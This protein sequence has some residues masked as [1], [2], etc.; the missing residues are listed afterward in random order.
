MCTFVQTTRG[1]VRIV[2]NFWKI[3]NGTY[4]RLHNL[5]LQKI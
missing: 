4:K 5:L 3:D 2:F 1:E